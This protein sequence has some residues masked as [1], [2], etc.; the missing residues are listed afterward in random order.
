MQALI[1][2]GANKVIMTDVREPAIAADNEVLLRVAAA[3]VCATDLAISGGAFG[4]IVPRILGHEVAGIVKKVG[5]GVSEVVPGDKVV[6]QPTVSCGQCPACLDKNPHLCP[7]R[8]F[9]GLDRDGGF[10]EWLCVPA[11]NL[12]KVPDSIP[13][14]DTCL[15]EPVACV[16]HALDCL[17][18]IPRNGVIIAGAGFSAFLFVQA[19]ITAGVEPEKII[20]SGRRKKRLEIIAALGAYTV[21]A[22]KDS[23]AD[24]A[25]RIFGEAGGADVFIDQTGDSSLLRQ[26][27]DM[28]KRRGFLFIYDFTGHDIPFNFGAMQ[29]REITIKTSTGCPDTINRALQL[30]ENGKINVSSAVTHVFGGGELDRAFATLT[31]RNPEHMKSVIEFEQ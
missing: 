6:I 7:T 24:R 28:L 23:L 22:R 2:S 13:A 12:V 15:A 9:I 3:G 1:R 25:R 21:D 10:A 26:S 19:F 18:T 5:R 30:M 11:G 17:G 29:L 31:D 4:G 20:V 27:L 8:Q 14:R 16:L